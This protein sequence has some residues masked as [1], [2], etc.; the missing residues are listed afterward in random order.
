MPC[1]AFTE[2]S[3]YRTQRDVTILYGLEGSGGVGRIG[4]DALDQ[5]PRPKEAYSK[6]ANLGNVTGNL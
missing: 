5:R 6:S 3:G 1:S 2:G 4:G